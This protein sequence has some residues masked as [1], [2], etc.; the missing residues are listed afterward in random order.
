MNKNKKRMAKGIAAAALIGVIAVGSTLAYLSATTGT[1]TNTFTGSDKTITGETIEENYEKD[2]AENYK[3]GDVIKKDP[4][5][6][7][8]A[9][10]ESAYV[11]LSTDYYGDDVVA[12]EIDGKTVVDSGTKMSRTAFA[13]YATINDLN[14]K[15]DKADGVWTLIAK[16]ANGSELYMYDTVLEPDGDKDVAATPLF[17]ST[18]VN[19][20]LRTITTT[21]LETTDVYTYV[22]ANNNGK[23]DEGEVKTPVPDRSTVKQNMTTSTDYIDGNGNTIAVTSLPPFV[24]DIKGFAVQSANVEKLDAKTELIKLANNGRTDNDIFTAV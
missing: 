14:A 18:T 21:E 10:S 19:A 15:P 11:A 23:Y 16:S 4:T 17:T 6:N 1:K 5:V 3:P 12:K 20:G 22:D 7:L 24:I 9:G 8:K 13:K 2:K